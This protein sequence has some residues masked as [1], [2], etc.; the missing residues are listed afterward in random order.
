MPSPSADAGLPSR[1]PP[2]HEAQ[3]PCYHGRKEIVMNQMDQRFGIAPGVGVGQL[4]AEAA[5]ER[6]TAFLRTVYGWMSVGLA[7]TATVSFFVA[8]S[9]DIVMAIARTRLL[10]WGI[11][12]A[13]FGL[14]ITMSA[15]VHKLAPAVAAGLFLGY[16]A[17][18]GVTMAFVLLAY[19]GESVAS[20]FFVTAG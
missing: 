6:I 15:R 19:T 4:S 3:P 1:P 5:G 10:F 14:V 11:I 2:A 7:V 13:Q 17:L 20:M 12:I 18:T 16:S 9:P 8:S